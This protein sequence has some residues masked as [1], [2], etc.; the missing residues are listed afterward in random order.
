MSKPFNAARACIVLG[1]VSGLYATPAAADTLSSGGPN[2]LFSIDDGFIG[3]LEVP[4]SMA[5]LPDGR[6]VVT[7]KGGLNGASTSDANVKLYEANGTYI[8]IAGTFDVS[9]L[10]QEQGLLKVLVHPDFA[11][12]RLLVFY[13]SRAD[14][15][16]TNRN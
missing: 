12:N 10:H 5:F 4:T 16:E 8:G 2:D 3:D 1:L 11:T 13:Y 6:I 7:E 14:G 9:D 15:T